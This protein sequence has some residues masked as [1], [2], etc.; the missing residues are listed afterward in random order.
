MVIL[1]KNG[2]KYLIFDDSVNENKTLLKNTQ[3]FGIKNEIKAINHG[4]ENYYETNYMKI[5]F[6]SNADLSFNKL[7]KFHAM[8]LIIRSVLR[9]VVNFIHK[10][11]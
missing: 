1:K 10:F 7:L 8:A 3:M 9:K 6:S 2:S 4:E 5:K 11:I